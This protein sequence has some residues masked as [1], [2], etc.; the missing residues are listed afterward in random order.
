MLETLKKGW[1][2]DRVRRA[3]R[4][5]AAGLVVLNAAPS[6]GSVVRCGFIAGKKVGGAVE[7]NR[8]R[9]LMREAVRSRL[10]SIKPGWDLVWIGRA[11]IDKA[12]GGKVLDDI[13]AILT[14][15]RLLSQSSPETDTAL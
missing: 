2:F 13:D 15:S 7:R 1:E 11:G 14:R 4:T 10:T 5:W 12:T 6:K 9:R 8:A 3:G